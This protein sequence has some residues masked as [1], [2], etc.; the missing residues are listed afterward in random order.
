MFRFKI[1]CQEHT[2]IKTYGHAVRAVR[3][4]L[5]DTATQKTAEAALQL[6]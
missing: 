4:A 6:K 2:D 5:G 3:I 1:F